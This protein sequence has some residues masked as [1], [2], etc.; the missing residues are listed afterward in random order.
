MTRAD[1]ELSG[2]IQSVDDALCGEAICCM[3]PPSSLTTPTPTPV[4]TAAA[5]AW[6]RV[7]PRGRLGVVAIG[8]AVSSI[9][10][11]LTGPFEP[12]APASG[13]TRM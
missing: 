4:A 3:D 8:A 6:R 13:I 5:S 9:G 11:R 1:S 10:A 12:R 7:M 2:D